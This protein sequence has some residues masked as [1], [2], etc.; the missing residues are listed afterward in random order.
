[1]ET[2]QRDKGGHVKTVPQKQREKNQKEKEK[3]GKRT[4][5][6]QKRKITY[7]IVTWI[8]KHLLNIKPMAPKLK[9]YLKTNRQPTNMT[10]NK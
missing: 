2:A 10:G 5:K 1:M 9:V 6:R 3:E 4:T 7:N 8:H